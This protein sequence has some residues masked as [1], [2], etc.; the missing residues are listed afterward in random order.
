MRGWQTP[1]TMAMYHRGQKYSLCG[2][3]GGG[4][5]GGGEVEAMMDGAC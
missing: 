5:G 1:V 4:G 3:G 2:G